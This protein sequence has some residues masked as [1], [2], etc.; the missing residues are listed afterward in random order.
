MSY[1]YIFKIGLTSSPNSFLGLILGLKLTWREQ[2]VIFLELIFIEN[3]VDV[4]D[5]KLKV[6]EE[7]EFYEFCFWGS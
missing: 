5:V 3:F 7:S 4:R 2:F 6:F 1:I